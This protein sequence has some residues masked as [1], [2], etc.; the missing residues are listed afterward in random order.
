MPHDLLHTASFGRCASKYT[1]AAA[2]ASRSW[3]VNVSSGLKLF[4]TVRT[5]PFASLASAADM[6][7]S[8]SV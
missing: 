8:A 7:K 5:F 3:F 6:P 2:I 1:T 4:T